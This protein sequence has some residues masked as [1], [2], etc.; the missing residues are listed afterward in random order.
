MN[1]MLMMFVLQVRE[2]LLHGVCSL[3]IKLTPAT[4]SFETAKKK[5][6]SFSAG[7]YKFACESV[8]V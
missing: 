3:Y 5:K 7:H 1:T 2:D 4:F 6:K 8:S